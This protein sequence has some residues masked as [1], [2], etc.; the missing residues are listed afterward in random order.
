MSDESTVQ[1]QSAE[2]VRRRRSLGR[3]IT[4][5]IIVVIV[6]V[7]GYFIISNQ[8]GAA[9]AVVNG[10]NITQS[11]YNDYYNQLVASAT[12]QG[13]SAT[14]TEAQAALK[15]QAIND[16]VAETLLLQEANKAGI[17]ANTSDVQS[18]LNQNKSQF[19]DNAAFES[20]LKSRGFT[21]ATF[22]DTLTKQNIIQ[23]LLNEK[24]DIA[25]ATATPAEITSLYDQVAA[26]NKNVPPLS[27]VR[28]QVAAQIVQ[29]KQQQLI[30]NYVAQ[31]KAS[32]TV[33]ILLK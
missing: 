23:Q 31:L 4:L 15:Q 18:A 9:V 26:S 10:E 20:A 7:A 14:T 11:E 2:P 24:L 27:Q 32:S 25:S 30:S 33:D 21:D 12:A 16:L 8:A 28:D 22:E 19:S 1:E 3:I 29:Q 5:I 6:V 13:Q 17:T